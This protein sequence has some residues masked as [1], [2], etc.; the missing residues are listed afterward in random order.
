MEFFF[1]KSTLAH[2]ET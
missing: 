1:K 2:F